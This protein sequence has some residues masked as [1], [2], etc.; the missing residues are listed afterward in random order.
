MTFSIIIPVYNS[1]R[2][3]HRCYES[4]VAQNNEA[5][6]VCIDDGSWDKSSNVLDEYAITNSELVV[7]HQ[8]NQGPSSVRNKG[9]ILST[10]DYVLFV[11]SDDY[12]KQEYLTLISSRL[13]IER[14]DI[15]I[16]GMA[17]S[18]SKTVPNK[19][20]H[21]YG[22]KSVLR[23]YSETWNLIDYYSCCNKAFSRKML[24]NN[25]VLFDEN[26]TVEEDF[27]FNLRSLD[28][29][30]SVSQIT[31]VL[32]YY[33]QKEVGS[34]TTSYNPRRFQGKLLSYNEEIRLLTKWGLLDLV[35]FQKQQLI[36]FVSVAVNNLLYGECSLS[37][38]GKIQ[39]IKKYF[40][41]PQVRECVGTVSCSTLR[42]KLMAIFIRYR[43][44]CSCY[45]LHAIVRLIKNCRKRVG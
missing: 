12:V 36:N 17:S 8:I 37:Y 1:E 6:I 40:N 3:F 41:N 34:L 24:V 11:D 27:V 29:A 23:H 30:E 15:L 21:H 28:V 45:F 5:S 4:V 20:E 16:Y 39:E 7:V 26:S 32:Y 2:F 44:Y 43:L 25:A 14:T 10:S 13:A 35:K 19:C 9:V 38:R 18:I 33:D 31:D 22:N 42:T